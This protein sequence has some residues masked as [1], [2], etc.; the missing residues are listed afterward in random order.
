MNEPLISSK[1]GKGLIPMRLT[2][3]SSAG[4]RDMY[5]GERILIFLLVPMVISFLF[6]ACAGPGTATIPSETNQLKIATKLNALQEQQLIITQEIGRLQAS[7]QSVDTKIDTLTQQLEAIHPTTPPH[8]GHPLLAKKRNPERLQ[9][10]RF[11]QKKG[12]PTKHKAPSATAQEKG[13]VPIPPLKLYHQAF[14]E[15]TNHKFHEAAKQFLEFVKLYPTHLYANNALYWAGESFYS[16]GNYEMAA[17]YFKEVLT[18]Y[19]KGNK[20]PA[21]LLKLGYTY[22]ALGKKKVAREY[23]FQLMD[24]YPFSAAAQKA[25][26]KLNELY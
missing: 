18:K 5:A 14:N 16:L 11:S 6:S 9:K 10:T 8:K 22:A 26:A 20:V 23:L 12:I 15:Y 19:P 24:Q 17:Y 3:D 7:I 1:Q 21:A 2:G 25:Q 13:P 4:K